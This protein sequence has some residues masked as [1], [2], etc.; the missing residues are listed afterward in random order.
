MYKKIYLLAFSALLVFFLTSCQKSDVITNEQSLEGT[1][2][3]TGITSDRA[4]DFNNDGRTETDLYGSYT[5]CQRDIV[6]T[7]DANGSGQ[8]RQ[9]CNAYW[10]NITWRLS[11]NNRQLDIILPDD[12]L[13]LAISQFDNYTLRGTD[14]VYLNGNTFNITYT[15]QRR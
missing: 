7:F 14:Q 6:A 2:V 12:Q 13:N 1:W 5:T 8:M 9:G 15:F 11:N 3:V 10:Q 4:Y